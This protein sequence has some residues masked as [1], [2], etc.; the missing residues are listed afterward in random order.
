MPTD[1]EKHALESIYDAAIEG[2]NLDAVAVLAPPFSLSDFL[3][4]GLNGY[5]LM[6]TLANHF[7]AKQN[8]SKAEE[9]LRPL[10]RL[11]LSE[12]IYGEESG[13]AAYKVTAQKIYLGCLLGRGNAAGAEI[14]FDTA[15]AEYTRLNM[16][17][18][19]AELADAFAACKKGAKL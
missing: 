15:V 17:D 10:L 3:D 19:M 2:K 8:F 11:D 14:V 9:Y 4:A 1:E 13:I 12:E 16:P 5:R 7:A 6:L 18:M